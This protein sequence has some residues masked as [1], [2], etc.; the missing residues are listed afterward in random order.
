[1]SPDSVH[2]RAADAE[3][4]RRKRRRDRR[5]LVPMTIDVPLTAVMETMILSG[6]LSPEQADQ[7]PLIARA[8]TEVVTDWAKLFRN[9]K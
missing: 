6:R 5:G 9:I 2:R 8:L 7:R 4:Q 1:M 3:R